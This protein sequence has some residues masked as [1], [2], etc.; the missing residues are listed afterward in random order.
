MPYPDFGSIAKQPPAPKEP[1]Q[2]SPAPAAAGQQAKL[3]A[4][5]IAPNGDITVQ[6]ESNGHKFK[7]VVPSSGPL[8]ISELAPIGSAPILNDELVAT[9][10]PAELYL[11]VAGPGATV[12]DALVNAQNRSNAPATRQSATGSGPIFQ[13]SGHRGHLQ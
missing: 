10:T 4:L 7:F 5:Q 13:D 12:P 2:W 6:T 3:G 8:S 11:S 1:A 9:K